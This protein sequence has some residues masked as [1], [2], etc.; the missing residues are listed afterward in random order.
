MRT[1]SNTTKCGFCERGT[2]TKRTESYM[3]KAG[4]TCNAC[5]GTGLA[6]MGGASSN[7][8]K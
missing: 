6:P 1:L 5:H 7:E 8:G 2:V 4:A 3:Q